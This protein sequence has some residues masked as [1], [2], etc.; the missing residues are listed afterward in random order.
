VL[1]A[2]LAQLDDVSVDAG[3]TITL[4][5]Q[6]LWSSDGLTPYELTISSSTP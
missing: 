5:G 2:E 4:D 1:V 6:S 3:Y